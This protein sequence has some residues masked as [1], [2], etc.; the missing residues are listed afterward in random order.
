MGSWYWWELLLV[1]LERCFWKLQQS[2]LCFGCHTLALVQST[3]APVWCGHGFSSLT[4][5]TLLALVGEG[6]PVIPHIKLLRKVIL[7]EEL[8]LCSHYN[9]IATYV[10][11]YIVILK[12]WTAVYT[13]TFAP[14]VLIEICWVISGRHVRPAVLLAHLCSAI[15][16]GV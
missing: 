10:C 1:L 7:H 8:L 14:L 13:K 15:S 9:V 5:Q 3:G 11:F 2:L 16:T 4:Y 6:S 12:T